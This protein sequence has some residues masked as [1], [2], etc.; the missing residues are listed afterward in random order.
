M[1][2][3]KTNVAQPNSRVHATHI[4]DIPEVPGPGKQGTLH[5]RAPQDLFFIKPLLARAEDE[6]TFPTHRNR[7]LDKMKRQR[8]MSQME[9]QG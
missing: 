1:T 5:Y 6:L 3:L 9:E 2:G 8:N 7:D 4:A